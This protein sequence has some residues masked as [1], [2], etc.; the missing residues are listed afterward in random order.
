MRQFLALVFC[1][2][3][4]TTVWAQTQA[5]W[6]L[7]SGKVVQAS[8]ETPLASV[9]IVARPSRSGTTTL[10]NGAFKLKAQP[11]DTITFSS[12]GFKNASYLVTKSA[13][14]ANLKIVLTEKAT[15]LN[16]VEITNRP[17]AEK[18]AR[19]LRNQKRPPLPDPVKAPPPGKPLFK[20]KPP[21]AVKVSAYHNPATFLYDKYSREGKENQKMADIL[22][23]IEKAKQ[24]SIARRKEA[25]YDSLFLDR[26]EYFKN[27]Y[28]RRW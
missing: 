3:I 14:Q 13:A 20:E 23:G 10:A 28:Y 9:S 5:G 2:F 1:F 25:H 17:S 19:A 6:V 15:D 26:N 24:D 12:L 22:E 21:V 16:E 7:V 4:G 8:K 18:I 27:P 11:G